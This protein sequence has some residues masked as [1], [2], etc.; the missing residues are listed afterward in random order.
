MPIGTY[1]GDI[2]NTDTH[3]PTHYIDQQAYEEH[4]RLGLI[5]PIKSHD[6]ELSRFFSDLDGEYQTQITSMIRVKGYNDKNKEAEFLIWTETYIG[7]NKEGS[8]I[9]ISD[10]PKGVTHELTGLEYYNGNP[11]PKSYPSKVKY[12]VPFSRE[13]VEELIDK[14]EFPESIQFLFKGSKTWGNFSRD[15]FINITHSE[16][17]MRGRTG[18]AG[19]Y[20]SNVQVKPAQTQQY[21]VIQQGQGTNKK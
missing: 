18:S 19:L 17:E 9:R 3:T 2:H 1:K 16:G 21:Q 20:P 12:T 7:R 10:V 6:Q 11:V 15:E 5:Y 13:K 14:S 4:Q 8:S